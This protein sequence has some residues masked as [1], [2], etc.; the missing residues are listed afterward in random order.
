MLPDVLTKRTVLEQVMKIYD[1]LGLVCLFTLCGKV[2]L[3]ELWSLKLDWDTPLPAHPTAKWVKFFT[4]MFPLEQLRLPRCL[5]PEDAV[6]R[7][8]LIILS[9][10]SDIAYGFAAYVR[11]RLEDGTFWCQLIMAKCRIAPLNKIST[12]QMELNAALLSKRSRREVIESE[13]R[14]EFEKVLQLIDSETVLS[15]IN[16]TSTRFRVYEGVRVGEIQAATNGNMSC[17]AWLSGEQNTA[18]WLTRGRKP[19]QIGDDSEWWNGPSFL[20]QLIES[21]GLKF[22]LQK[23]EPLPGEKKIRST[24]LAESEDCLIDISRFSKC[25]K[26]IWVLASIIGVAKHK[27]F[28][29]GSTS[30]ITPQLLQEADFEF[31]NPRGSERARRGN[32]KERYERMERWS[33]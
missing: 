16:K 13:M 4:T 26:L 2:Y 18:D 1:P 5:Q 19:D 25:S 23:E 20:Y 31:F 10:G 7:P 32:P 9:D 15:M 29:G 11:W 30:H 21:W 27:L 14:F 8:W 17:W 6:G 24:A 3:R 12:P 22:G 28:K 33:L